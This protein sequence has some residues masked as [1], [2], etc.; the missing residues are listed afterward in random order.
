MGEGR[1]KEG[2]TP[3]SCPVVRPSSVSV[4]FFSLAFLLGEKNK[5]LKTGESRGI[6]KQ[7]K[8]IALCQIIKQGR[9]VL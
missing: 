4:S 3:L 8:R 7:K 9:S 5:S 6:P 1:E 2:R